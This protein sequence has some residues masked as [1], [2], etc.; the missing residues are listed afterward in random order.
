V[1]NLIL[2]K[3]SSTTSTCFVEQKSHRITRLRW[4]DIHI[5]HFIDYIPKI[6]FLLFDKKITREC[7]EL[8]RWPQLRW[9]PAGLWPPL[10]TEGL[11]LVSRQAFKYTMSAGQGQGKLIQQ[12]SA[13]RVIKIRRQKSANRELPICP[14]W[15]T[16]ESP[17]G[18]GPLRT[19]RDLCKIV[20]YGINRCFHFSLFSPYHRIWTNLTPF[21]ANFFHLILTI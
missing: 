15:R 2:Q 3:N 7:V 12:P 20:S 5:S 1:N 11:E 13:S 6:G 17:P 21:C 14:M 18:G 4:L 10:Q 16:A 19:R 9:V 8:R